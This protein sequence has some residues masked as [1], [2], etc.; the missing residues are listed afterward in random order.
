MKKEPYRRAFHYIQSKLIQTL[1][2][3]KEWTMV[4]RNQRRSLCCREV[5]RANAHQQGPVS[6]Y[7]GNRIS[8]ALKKISEKEA[9]AY[10]S[11]QEFKE[12]LE[13]IKD[14]LLENKSEYL[15]SSEFAEL[16]EAID[17]FGF[18][19]ASIDMRQDSSA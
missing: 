18:Y 11:A 4:G 5:I 15:I 16:L 6:D 3:L 14:S 12:D 10:A 17:V 7:I 9:P 2:N 8:G 13:K 19:L 1:V